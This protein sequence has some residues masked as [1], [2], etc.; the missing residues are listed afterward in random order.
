M[1]LAR[2][3]YVFVKE[4]TLYLY[5]T[6]LFKIR[7]L[8][9]LVTLLIMATSRQ[10]I[11]LLLII[12]FFTVGLLII[13]G[14][15]PWISYRKQVKDPELILTFIANVNQSQIN[16]LVTNCLGHQKFSIQSSKDKLSRLQTNLKEA[17]MISK[18]TSQSSRPISLLIMPRENLLIS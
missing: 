10:K 16:S 18:A 8:L 3:E 2:N 9:P 1:K 7:M 4:I 13:I 5:L 17:I 14:S 15:Q 12:S 11:L 6:R